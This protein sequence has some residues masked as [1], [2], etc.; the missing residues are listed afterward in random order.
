MP[1]SAS[2]SATR[3]VFARVRAIDD[4]ADAGVARQQV[5]Q[6]RGLAHLRRGGDMQVRSMEAGDEHLRRLHLQRTQDVVARARIGGRGQRDAR[7]AGELIG[8]AGQPAILRA[9]L[10][11]PLRHAMRLV[12]REQRELQTRQPIQRAVASSRSGET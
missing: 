12:D 1:L 11:A 9:E 2:F 8:Q 7:H 4:A 5:E 10:V 3:S 6:L